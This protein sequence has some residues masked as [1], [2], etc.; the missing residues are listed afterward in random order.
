M[1]TLLLVLVDWLDT[2]LRR[3]V[4]L[5]LEVVALRHQ[6]AIYQRTCRRPRISPPDRLLWSCLARVWSGWRDDLFFV[7]PNTV[8][9]WQRKRFR[10][11][12]FQRSSASS[13][14]ASPERI[15]LGDRLA[16]WANW[17]SSASMSQNQRWTS[18]AYVPEG[19]HRRPGGHS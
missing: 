10:D 17:A 9:A 15:R 5:Q 8:T 3:R 14:A 19:H 13:S 1:R 11:Q 7:N 2:I 16:L 6:L 12:R 4:S 18:I